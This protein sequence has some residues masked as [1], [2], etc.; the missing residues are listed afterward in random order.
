[1]G[2]RRAGPRTLLVA[3]SFACA[4]PTSTTAE[5]SPPLLH[6]T[7]EA[8]SPTP[9]IA[10]PAAVVA[11]LDALRQT[12]PDCAD[13]LR[14]VAPEAAGSEPLP[15]GA[16]DLDAACADAGAVYDAQGR[17]ALY[18]SRG[19][20]RLAE[21]AARLGDDLDYLRR[22]MT[23]PGS[24]RR[25]AIEHLHAALRT[26]DERLAEVDAVYDTPYAYPASGDVSA[27]AP[28][29]ETD[30]TELD[31]A[32]RSLQNL[33]F[34]Q[35]FDPA[36]VRRRMLEVRG[37]A[38]LAD[39]DARDAALTAATHLSEPDRASLQ[40]SAAATRDA[41]QTYEAAWRAFAAGDVQDAATRDAWRARTAA[42][43][44]AAG[45]VPP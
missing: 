19:A 38:V 18:L 22:A 16:A 28:A 17:A 8:P 2:R 20:T 29:A 37:A 14:A 40:R 10:K 5:P 24:E 11:L 39:L 30:A 45:R 15:F 27:F 13:T 21:A 31:A 25:N 34:D 23:G 35:G 41:V 26:V 33:V 36:S 6:P 3:W 4:G 7:T 9:R 32:A 42:A 1:M 43:F 12:V 44:R